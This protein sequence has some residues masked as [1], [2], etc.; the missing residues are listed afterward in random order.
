M[1]SNMEIRSGLSSADEAMRWAAAEAAGE[2]VLEWPQ[3]AWDI[4]LQF[5]SSEDADVRA[6]IA[7]CV[8]EHLLEHYFQEYFP[9]LG[10][11]ISAG[12]IL[13]FDTFRTCW[14]FGQSKLSLNS[15]R[16][17]ALLEKVFG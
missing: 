14:K 5:G 3:D 16:W 8:L 15:N 13:L 11:R 7:T 12:D 2:I 6:A 4:V 10:E 9:Q 1:K 17:D